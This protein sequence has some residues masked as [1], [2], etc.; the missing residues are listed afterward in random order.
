ML[1][2][3][4]ATKAWKDVDAENRKAEEEVESLRDK[5]AGPDEITPAASKAMEVGNKLTKLEGDALAADSKAQEARKKLVEASS[6]V[7]ALWKQFEEGVKS[8][9]TWQQAMKDIATAKQNIATAEK[10]LAAAKEKDGQAYAQW[11]AKCDEIDRQER[12]ATTTA[13]TTTT[14]R[15]IRPYRHLCP[16]RRPSPRVERENPIP[17]VAG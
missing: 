17:V 8:D 13:I 7:A 5:G 15:V 3:L 6:K 11:Q 9:S 2:A 12:G 1:D 14:V 16:R 4:C 10:E